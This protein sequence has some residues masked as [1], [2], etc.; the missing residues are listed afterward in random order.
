MKSLVWFVVG[1]MVGSAFGGAVAGLV[2]NTPAEPDSYVITSK[3]RCLTDE[4]VSFKI[5]FE[6]RGD[7]YI[8]VVPP[9]TEA[10]PSG[11]E[12]QK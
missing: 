8:L 4:G 10:K 9:K 6:K 2:A 12:K 11:K 7:A 3:T 5:S 1:S